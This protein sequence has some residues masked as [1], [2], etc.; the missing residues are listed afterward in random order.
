MFDRFFDMLNTRAIDEGLRRKKP[1]LKVY[2]CLDDE[3]FEVSACMYIHYGYDFNLT[4][5]K[6]NI[7]GLP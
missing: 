5:A 1:D 3:R 7:S 4:V 6:R 2:E